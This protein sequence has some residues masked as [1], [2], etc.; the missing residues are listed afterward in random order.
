MI[1]IEFDFNLHDEVIIIPIGMKGMV[2]SLSA[3]NN[4]KQYRVVYWNDG[5]RFSS[6]LYAWEIKLLHEN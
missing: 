2:D 3:D 6:W 5:A 1:A 4:G